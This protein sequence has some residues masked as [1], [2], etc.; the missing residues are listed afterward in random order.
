MKKN[1]IVILSPF[2]I[3]AVN[4]FVAYAFGLIIGKWAFIPMILIGWVLWS[5]FILKYG[6]LKSIKRWL[7]KPRG[8]Y[9]WIAIAIIVGLLPLPLFIFHSSTL[10]DWT[11]WLPWIVLALI[12]PWIEEFYWRGLL[13][14][15]IKG[16]SNWFA[17]LYV[18]TL[19]ALNHAAFGINSNLNS[20][21]HVVAS[22]FVMGMVWGIIYL[23][24]RSLW[25]PIL[26][27][28]MVDFFNLS[29]ASFMDLYS[30]SW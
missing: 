9:Y 6:G 20:G 18:C 8:K 26:S 24:T 17:I 11:I 16:W 7:K 2:I 28:F 1:P 12:N 23:K 14:D 30:N 13:L 21:Y 22:T 29:A 3:I 15:S 27:H 4:L 25:W 10:A 19:F 5:F